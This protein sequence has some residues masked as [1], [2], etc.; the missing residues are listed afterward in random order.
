MKQTYKID[1]QEVKDCMLLQTQALSL[2]PV[3]QRTIDQNKAQWPILSAIAAQRPWPI[4]GELM[5]ID[6]ESWK[7]ILTAAYTKER[8]KLA[9]S[10]ELGKP[11][12]KGDGVVMI[13]KRTSKFSRKQF[14]EWLE[15]LNC[16]AAE[17]GVK[18]PVSKREAAMYE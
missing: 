15:F 1:T 12:N 7:D 11:G 2:E 18:V 3:E 16:A 6:A 14:P 13:G 5:L 17:L 4:D 10:F 8:I 9:K